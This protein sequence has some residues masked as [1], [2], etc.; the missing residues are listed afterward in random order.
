MSLVLEVRL[1]YNTEPTTVTNRAAETTTTMIMADQL[2]KN[3]Q[4]IL[5][6]YDA[7]YHDYPIKTPLTNDY[8]IKSPLYIMIIQ[9]KLP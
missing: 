3:H 2:A 5:S 9:S 1:L 8:P 6:G 7:I 4:I